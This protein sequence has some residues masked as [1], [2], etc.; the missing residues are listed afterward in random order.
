ME[1]GQSNR[2]DP[3]QVTDKFQETSFPNYEKKFLPVDYLD[4]PD[5]HNFDWGK[6]FVINER[7]HINKQYYPG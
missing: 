2:T 3:I 4:H 5:R 1:N 6:V 7:A